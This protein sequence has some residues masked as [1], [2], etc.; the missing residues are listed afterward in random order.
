MPYLGDPLAH[1]LTSNHPPIVLQ[2]DP[3][4]PLDAQLARIEGTVVISLV[5]NEQGEPRDLRVIE[6]LGHGLDDA[7]LAAVSNW[8]F[9][10]IVV[11]DRAEAVPSTVRVDFRL[12]SLPR[13]RK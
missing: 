11:N 3:A 7:A 8:K 10:P 4:Y 6:S 1:L 12:P 9:R 2:T 5:V 13:P